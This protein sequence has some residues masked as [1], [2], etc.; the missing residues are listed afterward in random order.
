[1][2][3]FHLNIIF[4]L[5]IL[6]LAPP[7]QADAL[8]IQHA[9]APWAIKGQ[10][11]T[12]RAKVTGGSGEVESVTLFYS[13]FRDAAPFRVSMASSGM[14]MYV[15]TIES[16]LLGG[17]SSIS[18]YIEAQDAEGS[19]E[20]TPW[21]DV[22]FRD[23][24]SA[25]L[26][27]GPKVAPTQPGGSPAPARA[28]ATEKDGLSA[29]TIG[30]IAGGAL[31]IGAGAYALSDSDSGGG[32]GSTPPGDDPGA[33]AGTYNGN[34]TVCME[35]GSDPQSCRTRSATIL[36]D[37]NGR[38]LSDNLVE[39]TALS[40]PLS[41]NSFSFSAPVS[42]PATGLSGT[43]SFSGTVVNNSRIVGSVSGSYVVGGTNGT[44][45]GTFA[46]TK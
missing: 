17:I 39:S 6:P 33:A 27:S 2:K 25:P 13:L 19:I 12:L 8:T 46:L 37:S 28:A 41:G 18:Y 23:P 45:S 14:G 7:A 3:L 29:T 44:F 5:A 32:G 21:Y 1:M 40:A 16:G 22:T 9:P 35:T 36:I 11:L 38:V 43:Q 42:D 31:A 15:G 26:A 20:E 30:L 34:V 24:E 10:S 4:F